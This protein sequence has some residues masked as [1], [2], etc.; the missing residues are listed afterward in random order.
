MCSCYHSLTFFQISF[1]KNCSRNTIEVSNGLDL[2]QDSV[3]PE[4][5]SSCL[6]KLSADGKTAACNE[7]VKPDYELK[8]V[9]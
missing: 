1:S 6:Q 5:G 4:L 2:D 8:T 3:S 7:R 9:F